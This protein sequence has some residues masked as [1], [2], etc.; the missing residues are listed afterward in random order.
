[1]NH[2]YYTAPVQRDGLEYGFD[3][4]G[5]MDDNTF[6]TDKTRC[7]ACAQKAYSKPGLGNGSSSR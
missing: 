3:L 1:M 2:P 6:I 5:Y 4:V 7:S